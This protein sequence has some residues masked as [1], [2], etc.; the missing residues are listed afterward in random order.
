MLKLLG[1][2]VIL[3]LIACIIIDFLRE[4]ATVKGSVWQRLLAAGK[5]SAT[6]IW[7]RFLMLIGAGTAALAE[8]ADLLNAPGVADTIKSYMQPQYVAAFIIV[9]A[10]IGELARW[11]TLKT[12][13]V[14][15][16]APAAAAPKAV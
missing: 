2:L 3:V 14:P 7:Q 11:R 4:F 10:L 1:L 13:P 6:I 15:A 5:G 9:A 8:L 12:L 16:S